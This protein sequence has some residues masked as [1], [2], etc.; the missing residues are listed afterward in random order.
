MNLLQPKLLQVALISALLIIYLIIVVIPKHYKKNE[1]KSTFTEI[2]NLKKSNIIV[3][4]I[5]RHPF[6]GLTDFNSNYL[7]KLLKNIKKQ[8]SISH[9]YYFNVNLLNDNEH[10]PTNEFL[11]SLA[12]KKCTLLILQ[13]TRINHSNAIMDNI[14]SNVAD[15]DIISGHSTGTISDH[16]PPFAIIPNMF[17]NT[18]SNKSNIYGNMFDNTT[19]NKSNIYKR[20]WCKSD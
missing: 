9:L 3:E 5:Y 7:N 17:G 19:N 20:D 8:K 13:P 2:V 16:L 18:T 4:V 14:F 1:L 6:I 12:S 11:D 15:P 10:N